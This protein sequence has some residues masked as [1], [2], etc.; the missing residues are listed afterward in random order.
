MSVK[1]Q[2]DR[3]TT[4]KASIKSAIE[5]KGVSVPANTKLDNMA[6]LIKNISPT[7]N[8]IKTI[9]GCTL[10]N[11]GSNA[12]SGQCYC[13]AVIAN[14][15]YKIESV[16]VLMGGADV[17]NQAWIKASD[18]KG[19]IAINKITGQ[20]VITAIAIKP[21]V[22]KNVARTGIDTSRQIYNNGLG[23][24]DSISL[25][26]GGTERSYDRFTTTGYIAVAP[27]AA[28]VLRFGGTAQ[29]SW[30][31][32]GHYLCTYDSNFKLLREVGY[33]NW[34]AGGDYSPTI[35]Q[36]SGCTYRMNLPSG[37]IYSSVA[38]IRLSVQ[39]TPDSVSSAY[40]TGHGAGLVISLDQSI[41]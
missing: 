21:Y 14:S 15:D 40:D 13:T 39:T 27:N 34:N 24:K 8:I 23:Y 1:T 22:C 12:I 10:N 33:A 31:T 38:Y 32:Y 37:L 3:L 11:T 7:Y 4:A 5:G 2:I 36:E 30:N 20:V 16:T 25:G 29:S 18:T 26:S 6:S 28:H 41:Y 35:V 17:T 9:I 19:V